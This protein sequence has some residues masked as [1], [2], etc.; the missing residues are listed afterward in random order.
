MNDLDYFANWR[1][2]C[3]RCEHC[4]WRGIGS[5]LGA[6]VMYSE[7]IEMD[8]PKCFEPILFYGCPS[9]AHARANG[10]KLSPLDR[11]LPQ[12]IESARRE[13]DL[14]RLKDASRLPQFC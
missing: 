10:S 8:C 4:G 13:F 5:E 3:W 1:A 11:E 2:V 14:V 12:A 6:G 7:V 9:T